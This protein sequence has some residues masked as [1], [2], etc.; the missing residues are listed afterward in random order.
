MP[1]PRCSPIRW[2]TGRAAWSMPAT[3]RSRTAGTCRRTR[4][5]GSTS[6]A[7]SALTRR[8]IR[9]RARSTRF[10][11][12]FGTMACPPTSCSRHP[13]RRGTPIT[14]GVAITASSARISTVM[15]GTW[16]MRASISRIRVRSAR[17]APMPSATTVR[18]SPGASRTTPPPA[19][20]RPV[21]R[22]TC[23]APTTRPS[24]GSRRT[25]T[26]SPTCPASTPTG[27]AR[28]GSRMKP[29]NGSATPSSRWGT[30]STGPASS[31]ARSRRPAPTASTCSSG[32][33]TRSIG[34]PAGKSAFPPTARNTAPL[35]ATRRPGRTVTR[36]PAPRTTPTSTRATYGRGRGATTAS[37][38]TR[39]PAPMMAW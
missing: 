39:W 21:R 29:A 33:A 20:R 34:R 37:A 1:M 35:S 32:A 23:S 31:A 10:R 4:C 19:D 16:R 2:S 5:P 26:T 25:A 8:A 36:M 9:S 28:P 18:S 11:S 30:T 24:T 15:R 7:F 14:A 12:S 17:T 27:W 6:R 13:T 22:T 3:G 38:P